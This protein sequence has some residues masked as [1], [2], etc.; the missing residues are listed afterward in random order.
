MG[1]LP[2]FLH[3][4][5]R[6]YLKSNKSEPKVRPHIF[7]CFD[8]IMPFKFKGNLTNIVRGGASKIQEV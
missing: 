1:H 5:I 4:N 2:Y 7:P 8:N 6:E 3:K